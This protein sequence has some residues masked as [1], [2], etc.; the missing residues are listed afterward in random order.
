LRLNAAADTILKAAARFWFLT[1][2]AGQWI[3]VYYIAV[4]YGS[5]IFGQDL[6]GLRETHLPNGFV[7]GDTVGNLDVAAHVLLAV[8]IMGGGPLQFI[9]Q[10]RARF[11]VFHR[12]N[13]RLYLLTVFTVSLAGL[14][15]IWTRG[16]IGGRVGD[17]V[18]SVNAALI[19]V[20]AILALRSAIAR[21]IKTHRRWRCACFWWPAASGSSGSG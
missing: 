20:F 8:I 6:E 1:A 7:S 3:F 19:I 21:D 4:F 10:I 9:P 18:I 2:L 5:L 15:L 12:W 16:S 11:P 14:Y 13:G 17:I